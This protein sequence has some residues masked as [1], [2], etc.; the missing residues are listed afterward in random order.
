MSNQEPSKYVS[1]RTYHYLSLIYLYF[2]CNRGQIKGAHFFFFFFF[3]LNAVLLSIRVS[4]NYLNCFLPTS[5]SNRSF[6]T[7]SESWTC[8]ENRTSTVSSPNVFAHS[9]IRLVQFATANSSFLMLFFPVSFGL[10]FFFD[11]LM[12]FLKSSAVMQLDK[13]QHCTDPAE[14]HTKH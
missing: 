7:F 9:I 14:V 2:L 3:A 8:D 11:R 1:V 6:L 12:L 13:I 4:M 10:L 5:A